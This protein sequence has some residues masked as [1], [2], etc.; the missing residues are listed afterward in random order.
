M[1]RKR[2]VAALLLLV[3]LSLGAACYLQLSR[4]TGNTVADAAPATPATTTSNVVEPIG[5]IGIPGEALRVA[6]A[7]TASVPDAQPAS[8]GEETSAA[9][10]ADE[11]AGEVSTVR[12]ETVDMPS[13]SI[14]LASAADSG[15]GMQPHSSSGVG[16]F[17][18]SSSGSFGGGGSAGGAGP[19][20]G[21]PTQNQQ[22][23]NTGSSGSDSPGSAQPEGTGPAG[24]TQAGTPSDET[25]PKADTQDSDDPTPPKNDEE[26]QNN[27]EGEGPGEGPGE[28]EG[29]Q[30]PLVNEPPYAG[31]VNPPHDDEPVRVPEPSTLALLGVGGLMALGFGRRRRNAQ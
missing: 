9:V 26:Q 1:S 16:S 19:A 15:D 17:R 5:E 20:G 10:T 12:M 13:N 18:L 28:E 14:V 23:S 2:L 27:D 8:T 21:S 6:A 25:P 30:P 11:P 7:G 24:N 31:P 3:T 22:P 4:K 29:E